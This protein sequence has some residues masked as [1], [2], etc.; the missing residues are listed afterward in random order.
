MSDPY[1]NLHIIADMLG[2]VGID[3][4]ASDVAQWTKVQQ[5]QAEKY[6][7]KAHLRA[8]DNNVRVPTMP[9]FLKGY[10]RE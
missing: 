5:E 4:E 10:E 6:A 2:L 9:A 8:S 3:V 7:A 1:E